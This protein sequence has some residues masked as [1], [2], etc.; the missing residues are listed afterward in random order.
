[1]GRGGGGH[2]IRLVFNYCPVPICQPAEG[3]SSFKVNWD[4]PVGPLGACLDVRGADGAVSAGGRA[5]P[6]SEL[7]RLGGPSQGLGGPVVRRGAPQVWLGGQEVARCHVP[8][9][10]HFLRL[11]KK[12]RSRIDVDWQ[13]FAVQSV[14]M[15]SG[16]QN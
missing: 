5:G 7:L 12:E 6:G 8:L 13:W 3:S 1:M 11:Q 9:E 15:Y 14:L 16:K 4:G 2:K 10:E